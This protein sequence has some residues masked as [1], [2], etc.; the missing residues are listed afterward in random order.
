MPVK[1]H[2]VPPPVGGA[3]RFIWVTDWSNTM[4]ISGFAPTRITA[5]SKMVNLA[6]SQTHQDQNRVRQINARNPTNAGA[7]FLPDSRG[8]NLL[9]NNKNMQLW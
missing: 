4:P 2:R 1:A 7:V 6:G 9:T 3:Q 8:E 5:L